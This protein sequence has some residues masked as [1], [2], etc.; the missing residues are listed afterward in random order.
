[1]AVTPVSAGADGTHEVLKPSIISG[2]R[3]HILFERGENKEYTYA[4][5][6]RRRNKK[7]PQVAYSETVAYQN[8]M[9]DAKLIIIEDLCGCGKV[10]DNTVA[11]FGEM[12]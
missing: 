12:P 2:R 5:E 4:I 7:P 11:Y 9:K 6:V 8:W 1:M 10:Q 3:Q